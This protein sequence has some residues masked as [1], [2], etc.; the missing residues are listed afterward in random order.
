MAEVERLTVRAGAEV[1]DFKK[2]MQSASRELS[3]FEGK[4]GRASGRVSMAFSAIGMAA[5]PLSVG[6]AAV[7]G[8][9]DDDVFLD[10]WS[11]LFVQYREA[12]CVNGGGRSFGGLLSIRPSWL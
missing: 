8:A 9:V 7:G 6:L 11:Y 5:G 12:I 3:S 2:G 10:I 1:A 4:A